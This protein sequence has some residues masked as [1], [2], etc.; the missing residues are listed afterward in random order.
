MFNNGNPLSKKHSKDNHFTN[1]LKAFFSYLQSNNATASM[2]SDILGIPQKNI[3]RY[4]R[5]L[6]KEGKLWQTHKAL[7]RKTGFRAFY[8]T[9]N[10]EFNPNLN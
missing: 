6:E 5:T 7:C 4:K 2:V 1:E 9:T 3:C 8:L 10:P